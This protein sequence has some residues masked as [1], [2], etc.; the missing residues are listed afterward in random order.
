[1]FNHV[2]SVF[3]DFSVN[4]S[5]HL[6]QCG[7]EDCLPGH[8]YGFVTRDHHLIHFVLSGKGILEIGSNKY[9]I[10]PLQGFYIPTGIPA[11]YQADSEDPWNY[12]WFGFDG[13]DSMSVLA[14][15]NLS[16]E[17]PVFSFNEPESVIASADELLKSYPKYG[18]DF[19]VISVLYRIFSLINPDFKLDHK[20][21]ASFE[22]MVTYIKENYSSDISIAKMASYFNI[23]QSQLFRDFKA[24]AKLSPQQYIKQYRIF[25][26]AH[27]LSTTDLTVNQI[28]ILSGYN[29]LCNFSKQFKSIYT[30]SPADYRKY[31]TNHSNA[32]WEFDHSPED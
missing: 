5:L 18:N 8:A 19:T 9:E 31:I 10:G 23:S 16:T 12:C 32:I 13:M 1:M 17:R 14:F 2:Y 27:L 25:Q 11:K 20:K 24:V 26:A 6:M 3:P 7:R 30:R 4:S 22:R 29:D 28:S 15:R 21:N